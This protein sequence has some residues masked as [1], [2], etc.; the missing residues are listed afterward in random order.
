MEIKINIMQGTADWLMSQ[1]NPDA[2]AQ[3]ALFYFRKNAEKQKT[4][5]NSSK[6]KQIVD[7]NSHESLTGCNRL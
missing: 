4:A 2:I 1:D 7:L 6:S 3:V 5:N